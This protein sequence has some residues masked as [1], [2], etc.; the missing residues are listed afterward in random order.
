MADKNLSDRIM[1][2]WWY[3]VAMFPAWATEKHPRKGARFAGRVASF[4]CFVVFLPLTAIIAMACLC[5]SI[6]EDA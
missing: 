5:L 3:R 2:D 6:W 1:L 4:P